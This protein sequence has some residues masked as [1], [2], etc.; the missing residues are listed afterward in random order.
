MAFLNDIHC[1]GI[2]GLMPQGGYVPSGGNRIMPNNGQIELWKR[3]EQYADKCREFKTNTLCVVGDILTGK[4]HIEGGQYVINIELPDQVAMAAQVIH[5]F[6]QMVGTIDKIILWKS[7]GYHGSKDGSVDLEVTKELIS[8]YGYD[9]DYMGE[10]AFIDI[11]NEH[12]KTKRMFVTHT[13]P[14]SSMYPE[15]AMGKDI[16]LW[17]ESVGQG[18]LDPT[19]YIIRAHKHYYG[20]VH[21]RNMRCIQL[22]CWQ[23]FVPYDGAVKNFSKWQPDIG[24]FIMMFDEELRAQT[25]HFLYPPIPDV[26]KYAIITPSGKM[27][28]RTSL[29]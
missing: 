10:Y 13:A 23:M 22:P 11:E 14:N 5:Q 25:M 2:F 29:S 27:V 3:L 16:M 6:C 7:T 21:R 24:G 15:Q 19:D 17:N 18:K 1:G 28:K 8:A 12:G 4:N 20:E 9:A 26:R